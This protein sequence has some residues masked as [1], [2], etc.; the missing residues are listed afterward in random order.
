MPERTVNTKA[1]RLD[2]Y[3]ATLLIGWFRRFGG[4]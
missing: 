4:P 2:L 3:A 1:E